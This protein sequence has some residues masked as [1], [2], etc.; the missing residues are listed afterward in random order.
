[1]EIKTII[2][3]TIINILSVYFCKVNKTE[4]KTISMN[5]NQTSSKNIFS[6]FINKGLVSIL[7]NKIRN[8]LF[9]RFISNII[10]KVANKRSDNLE[11]NFSHLSKIYYINLLRKDKF[12]AF[13]NYKTND[14]VINNYLSCG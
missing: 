4:K 9:K 6:K 13:S 3:F 10:F 2:L 1:M 11:L 7:L 12:S 8:T 14:K 5:L